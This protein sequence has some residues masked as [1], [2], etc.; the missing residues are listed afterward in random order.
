[1]QMR[2]LQ[3]IPAVERRLNLPVVSAAVCTTF[4][5]LQRLNF[6]AVVP[7]AGTLLSGRLAAAAE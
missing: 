4:R 2:S 5:M 3:S 1:V 6:E 7:D